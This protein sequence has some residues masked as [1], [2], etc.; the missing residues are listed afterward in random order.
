MIVTGPSASTLTQGSGVAPARYDLEMSIHHDWDA[1]EQIRPRWNSILHENHLLTIFSTPEW[2]ESWWKAYGA[3]KEL[4]SLTFKDEGGAV[5]GI[6]PLYRE[7]LWE[8]F[9]GRL[10]GLRLVGDG[11]GDSDNLDVPVQQGYERAVANAVIA[12]LGQQANWAVCRFDT[13]PRNSRVFRPLVDEVTSRRWPHNVTGVPQWHIPLPH[14]WEAY[15]ERL[16]PE[17]RPLLTRYPRRLLS[18]YCCEVVRCSTPADLQIYLPVLF[19][20]HQ[21]RW[22][23][24]GKPGSFSSADRRRFYEYMAAAFLRRGWLEFWI[25]KLNSTP[26]AAQFCFRYGNSVYL[27]QEGFDPR[28]AKDKVGYALR[29]RMLQHYIHCG[30]ERYDFLGGTQAYKQKFGAIKSSY[31]NLSLAKPRTLGGLTVSLQ[32]FTEQARVWLRSAVPSSVRS[33]IR[34]K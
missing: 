24:V 12:W 14:T 33:Q 17:F 13:L 19:E 18:R 9:E 27:L 20:L 30:I 26:A 11:S 8:W 5:V 2:L 22:R 29:A 1:M 16:S 10:H 32:G 25:L 7:L 4:M 15:L 21:R 31:F 23:Q 28:Y 6:V 34:V 3:G